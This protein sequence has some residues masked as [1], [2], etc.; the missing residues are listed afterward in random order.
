MIDIL[1]ATYNGEKYVKEQIESIL[2]QTYQ[3]W[4]LYIRDDGSKDNTLSILRDFQN[5]HKERIFLVEDNKKGLGAKGNFSEL[6]QYSNSEYCMF[7]DQDDVWIN[8]KIEESMKK[9]QS[10]ES[11]KNIPILVHSDL[12]VVDSELKIINESFWEYQQL[13]SSK[14]TLNNLLVQNNITGCTM[15]MNK[16][17]VNICRDI[18][19]NCIMHDWWIG[20]VASAFGKIYTVDNQTILYRQH[21]NNEV[22]AHKYNSIG[23]IKDKLSNIDRINKSIDD[24]L[25][26]A[27]V[28][29]DKF[30]KILGQ[31]EKELVFDF[32][33]I[34][35]KNILSRKLSIIQNKY[36]KNGLVR[37]IGYLLFI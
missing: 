24:A 36:Y 14:N 4:K 6:I 31:E 13:D 27:R 19:S 8:T 32:A 30:G 35:K 17:L 11:D 25:I 34:R 16:S 20:L 2:N 1:M 9:M 12:K 22:G 5:K 18:P 21:G 33:N 15:L 28:F 10:V 7:S 26:Q 37:N 29:Y 3:E 23:F